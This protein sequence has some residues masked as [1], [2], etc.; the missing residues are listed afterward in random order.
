MIRSE[1]F[2]AV[3]G[4]YSPR[5]CARIGTAH[6]FSEEH[7]VNENI[8]PQLL[9]RCGKRAAS[10]QAML[11]Q[12]RRDSKLP[13]G[14]AVL[15]DSASQTVVRKGGT[16]ARACA[17][18][19]VSLKSGPSGNAQTD[20]ERKALEATA[21]DRGLS[22]SRRGRFPLLFSQDSLPKVIKMKCVKKPYETEQEVQKERFVLL[23]GEHKNFF[24]KAI[25]WGY[26]F[27]EECKAFHIVRE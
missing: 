15:S 17:F 10:I 18:S 19:G 24:G 25:K 21:T 11:R 23:S 20:R 2:R 5:Q 26:E 8:H 12:P 4:A 13:S 9:F 22:I 16:S 1:S 27:C 6:K 7:T 14:Q 3:F